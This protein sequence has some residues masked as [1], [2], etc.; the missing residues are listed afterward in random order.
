MQKT[1]AYLN[2]KDF[3]KQLD[4]LTIQ[5]RYV[6]ITLLDFVNEKPIK[7][8]EGEIADGSITKD[9][10]SAVRR[11]CS[12]SCTID[13]YSYD[14]YDIRSQYSINKKVFIEVGITNPFENEYGEIIWFPQGVMLISSF[15]ISSTAGGAISIQMQFKDKMSLLDGTISGILPATTRF[16]TVNDVVDGAYVSRKVLVKDIILEAVNHLGGEALVN[17][18]IDDVPE[19]AKRQLQWSY[20]TPLWVLSKVSKNNDGEEQITYVPARQDLLSSSVTSGQWTGECFRNGYDVGYVC[21]DFVY[22]KELTL[23][24]GDTITSLLDTLKKWL[25]NFEYFY[26]EYGVFHFQEIKN[27]LNNSKSTYEWNQDLDDNDYSYNPVNSDVVYEFTDSTNLVSVSANPQYQNIKNDYIIIG[28][29]SSTSAD[30]MYHFV[31]DEKPMINPDGYNNILVYTDSLTG[32]YTLAYPILISEQELADLEFGEIGIIYGILDENKELST[33]KQAESANDFNIAMSNLKTKIDDLKENLWNNDDTSQHINIQELVDQLTTSSTK[34]ESLTMVT[35]L[36]TALT[37]KFLTTDDRR[38][39]LYNDTFSFKDFCTEKGKYFYKLIGTTAQQLSI[40]Y[41]IMEYLCG[42]DNDSYYKTQWI[43]TYYNNF[44]Y[45]NSHYWNYAYKAYNSFQEKGGRVIDGG[46]SSVVA[47]CEEGLEGF[48]NYINFVN[49]Y[50]LGSSFGY[51]KEGSDS[52]NNISTLLSYLKEWKTILEAM[53]TQA[54][55]TVLKT[56][57]NAAITTIDDLVYYN[58]TRTYYITTCSFYT[59]NGTKKIFEEVDWTYYYDSTGG[60]H[61]IDLT[62]E[63]FASLMETTTNSVR[64]SLKV[65]SNWYKNILVEYNKNLSA[66]KRI[67]L[68]SENQLNSY[69]AQN[70]RT[71]IILQGL[72]ASINGEEVSEYYSELIANWPATYDLKTQSYKTAAMVSDD[73]FSRDTLIINSDGMTGIKYDSATGEAV[74]ITS[75]NANEKVYYDGDHLI[76]DT[77]YSNNTIVGNYYFDMLDAATSKWGEYSVSNIGRR[78]LVISDDTINCLFVQTPPTYGFIFVENTQDADE[79]ARIQEER[80]WLLSNGCSVVMQVP[81]SIYNYFTTGGTSNGAYDTLRYNLMTHIDYQETI[82]LSARSIFYL[83]PNT[84]IHLYDGSTG[85][86]GN[87]VITSITLPLSISSQMSMNCSKAIQKV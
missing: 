41:Y 59:W 80:E 49:T 63:N 74:T 13:G 56:T 53:L 71:E 32:N 54:Y 6:K 40:M 50:L 72:I 70:W 47:N 77:A 2:D 64:G 20:G 65:N 11:T 58:F 26:D 33:T 28:K 37:E 16:D 35:Q 45:I 42:G 5:E 10:S 87:Y 82:S 9:G 67:P 83:S 15:S 30:V 51:Y 39:Y 84:M 38:D 86:N 52:Y 1:Y 60:Y 8:I 73:Y 81:S 79:K 48:K 22:D 18:V 27:Y 29:N 85:I 14:I 66:D 68:V 44:D 31:I 69:I 24:A 57:S 78:R 55:L 61:N 75:D 3:L 12:L 4:E 23:N 25:G 34:M 36:C 7:S 76:I 43:N 19:K 17:I 21:E 46:Y 62:D